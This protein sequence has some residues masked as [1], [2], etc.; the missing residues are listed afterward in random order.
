MKYCLFDNFSLL[1]LKV[2]YKFRFS[3]IRESDSVTNHKAFGIFDKIIS[4]F[5]SKVCFDTTYLLKIKNWKL[6]VWKYCS[7]ILIKMQKIIHL[8]LFTR[9]YALTGSWTVLWDQPKSQKIQTQQY[10]RRVANPRKGN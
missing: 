9:F 1:F 7:K 6:I 8:L 10:R 5:T 2:G 4:F 3:S